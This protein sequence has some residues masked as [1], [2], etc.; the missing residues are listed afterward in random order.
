MSRLPKEDT[1]IIYR[2]ENGVGNVSV[3]G[4]IQYYESLADAW[5]RQFYLLLQLVAKEAMGIIY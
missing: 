3:L 5:R 1:C 4:W 2:S